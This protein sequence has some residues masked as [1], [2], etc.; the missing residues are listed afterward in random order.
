MDQLQ[1]TAIFANIASENLQ[2]FKEL[3]GQILDITKEESGILQFDFFFDADETTCV[4]REKYESSDAVLAHLGN[5]AALLGQ[6][7]EIAKFSVEVFGAPSAQLME[8][9]GAMQPTVS[10]YF[11]GV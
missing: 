11:A 4:V 10:S 3:V 9:A 1:V 5:T 2:R 6:L 8:A 7:T